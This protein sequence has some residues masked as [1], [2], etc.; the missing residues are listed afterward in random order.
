ME[1]L[2]KTYDNP[3]RVS[4]WFSRYDALSKILLLA[5]AAVSQYTFTNICLAETIRLKSGEEIEGK[6]IER[7]DKYIKMNFDDGIALTYYIDE[8]GSI[9]GNEI[10]YS[11]SKIESNSSSR[12][13][14]SLTD[15]LKIGNYSQIETWIKELLS[16]RNINKESDELTDIYIYIAKEIPNVLPILN[17]WCNKSPNSHVPWTARGT[18]YVYY[19]WEARGS[20]WADSV[21]D[22][23]AILFIER[24]EQ[25]QTDLEKAYQLNP[26]DPNAPAQLINVAMGLGLDSDY[27]ETQFQR[28]IKADPNHFK[29]HRT[30]LLYLMPK[31]YGSADKVFDFIRQIKEKTARGSRLRL[32]SAMA[33]YE[34]YYGKERSRYFHMPQVWNEIY[35]EYKGYLT[36]HP[37][38][39]REHNYLAKYAFTAGQFEIAEKE[40]KVIGDIW[41]KD[42]WGSKDFFI[43][44]KNYVLGR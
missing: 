4:E 15:L 8:I 32:I 28:A 6:V 37:N 2:V 33:Y 25:A 38:D 23:K 1:G 13:L 14:G 16:R 7:T 36:Q 35:N 31:W 20:E 43:R 27:M 34:L 18:F 22:D 44:S 17:D 5:F 42:C 29:A 3:V 12:Y 41:D 11:K 30:K 39:M 24:L 9:I 21:T 19:A 40:F 26:E 10:N